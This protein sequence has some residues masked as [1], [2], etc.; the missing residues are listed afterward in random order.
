MNITNALYRTAQLYPERIASVHEGRTR[1]WTDMLR[2]VA[3][4]GGA[5][6][7]RGIAAGERVALL[8]WNTDRYLE[9]ALAVAWAG[10]VM[11]PLNTRLAISELAYQ[12]DD[13]GVSALIFDRGFEETAARLC[14][15]RKLLR[16]RIAMEGVGIAAF[17]DDYEALVNS[18]EPIASV[19]RRPD[20]LLGI[21]Y[22]SGTSGLPKGVMCTHANMTY[23]MSVHTMNA[24]WTSETSFLHVLPIFHVGGLRSALC[25]TALGA[26]QAYMPRFDLDQFLER[27]ANEHISA[28]GLGPVMISWLL[29]HPKFGEHD[30]SVL[31][32][33]L[34]GTSLMPRPVLERALK[35][36]PGVRFMQIYG[37]TENNG[38]ITVLR[39]EEHVVN[40]PGADRLSS[41]GRAWWG[42]H[43][44]V[45]DSE[46]R[47]AQ[48]GSPGEI[49]CRS[50]SVMTGYWNDQKQSAEAI[51]KGWLHTGDVGYMDDDGYIF[52]VDRI[53]DMIVSGGENVYSSEVESAISSLPGVA[54][55][56]VIGIPSERWGES[57]HAIVVPVQGAQITEQAVIAHCRSRITGYK[58]PKTVEIRS[59]LL[60]LSAANKILK[61]M[62]RE[63]YLK[64]RDSVSPG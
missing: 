35:L 49:V 9:A 7:G 21:Y 51:R 26:R 41:A 56:A 18:A 23:Q 24:G 36:L 31:K 30:L 5:L 14:E 1:T 59:E 10:A 3:R 8:G 25:A 46:G 40:G 29:D 58:C 32:D 12:L 52:V 57:V 11:V 39:P 55:V 42:T 60:P 15:D 4:L 16:L 13:A 64:K 54:Q 22:T 61:R 19:D 6:R 48:R 37:Q 45:V 28:S 50:P 34:Y 17:A 63:P 27:V 47:E 20:D 2:R 44:R 33:I 38:T 53:K 62:L 43:A